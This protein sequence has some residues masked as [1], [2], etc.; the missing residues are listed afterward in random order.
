M[1][2]VA[3]SGGA[4]VV[5]VKGPSFGEAL[6]APL[7]QGDVLLWWLGGAGFLLRSADG[8]LLIDP[9][10]TTEGWRRFPPPFR[11]E[12]ATRVD[13]VLITHEHRDHLDVDVVRAFAEAGSLATWVVPAPLAGRLTDLGIPQERIVAAQPGRPL[14]LGRM[15]VQPIPAHHGVSMTDAYN[16]GEAIS[17][18]LVRY[19]GYVMELAGTRIYH[20][21]DCLAYPGLA[22][23]L[24]RLSVDVVLLPI[25]GRDAEREA[26]NIVGNMTSDEAVTLAGRSGAEVMVPMHWDLFPDNLGDPSTAVASVQ[27][28]YP[29]LT[30]LLPSRDRPFGLH[31]VGRHWWPRPGS[32]LEDD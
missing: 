7:A 22:E 31:H 32:R 20:S 6:E 13:A 15:N 29:G 3:H 24:V 23:E 19:L 4:G 1:T 12:D 27:R 8:A 26:I 30:V 17:G 28:D 5:S 21:G 2:N 14:E 10:L 18:G 9:Y 25:N 11:A 16:T